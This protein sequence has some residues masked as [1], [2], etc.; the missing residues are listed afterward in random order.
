ML[1]ALSVRLPEQQ[2]GIKQL[3]RRLRRDKV[4]IDI[5][6]ARGVTLKHITYISYSGQVRLDKTDKIIGSQRSRLLC[7]DNLVFPH[8]SGYMRFDSRAFTSRLCS[9]AALAVLQRLKPS[10]S[11]RLGIVDS[12]GV[13]TELMRRALA[14]CADVTVITDNGQAY[15]AETE[16]AMD[17]LGAASF[18]TSNPADLKNC[19][20]VLIPD[21]TYAQLCIGDN[22]LVIASEPPEKPRENWFY[23]YKVKMPNGFSSLKPDELDGEYFCSALYTLGAQYELG[24]MVPVL[25]EADGKTCTIETLC[26]LLD[27]PR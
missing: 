20:L 16:R 24:S 10:C 3:A 11:V 4:Q 14:F 1:T 2:T 19:G 22:A 9:N 27:N 21:K 15:R 8:H 13:H 5:K 17:E 6:R 23:R 26:A 7:S 18:V 25:V 12:R